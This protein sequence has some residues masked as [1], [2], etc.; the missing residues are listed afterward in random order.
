MSLAAGLV[1]VSADTDE[2][3]VSVLRLREGN[4]FGRN[5]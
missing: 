5:Q 3:G 2:A 4:A 1:G